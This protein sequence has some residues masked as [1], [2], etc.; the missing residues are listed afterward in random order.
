MLLFLYKPNIVVY[1]YIR[2]SNRYGK[3]EKDKKRG[4]ALLF[5]HYFIF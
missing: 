1:V 2:V 5:M 4:R 3:G